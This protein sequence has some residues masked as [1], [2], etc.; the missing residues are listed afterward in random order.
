MKIKTYKIIFF[1]CVCV[2]MSLMK[3]SNTRLEKVACGASWFVF[4]TRYC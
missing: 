2:G 1:C 4:L 3:G